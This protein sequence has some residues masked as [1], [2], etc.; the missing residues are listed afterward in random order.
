MTFL[1]LSPRDAEDILDGG[2]LPGRSDLACVLE[3]AAFM[4]ATGEVEPAP[5]MRAELIY[6]LGVGG[7]PATN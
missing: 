3:L 2:H 6:L 5:P 1:D 7:P 4:R